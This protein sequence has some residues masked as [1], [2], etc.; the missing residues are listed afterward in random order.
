MQAVVSDGQFSSSTTIK[1]KTES[2]PRTSL[3]F[4]QDKYFAAV[5]ENS[6]DVDRV[7]LVQALGSEL[8]EHL[9][10]RILNPTDAFTIGETSGVIMTT[11]KPFDREEQD[12]YHL[13]AEVRSTSP[14]IP[15]RISHVPVHIVILDKNDN[16]PIF[17][18]TPY[19]GIVPVD[20]KRDTVIF[21][22]QATDFDADEN[23]D[24]RYEIRRGNTELFA[25]D[26]QKGEIRIRQELRGLQTEYELTLVAYD[27]G[28]PPLSSEVNVRLK[29]VD[30][31][32]PIF[33]QQFYSGEIPES[34][35]ISTP[36]LTVE[37]HSQLNRKLIYTIVGG[38]NHYSFGIAHEEG[39]TSEKQL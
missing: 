2:L 11:G 1:I 19:Y 29:V 27:G 25:V 24:V 33:R 34:A 35:E 23:K 8:N 5:E 10:F 26:R 20:S 18:N 12:A 30:K 38:E 7:V 28:S 21:K 4:S 36:V 32:Q 39:K 22:V 6:H 13:V 14:S 3:R 16:D 17:V 15:R 31:S 37:A 9:K